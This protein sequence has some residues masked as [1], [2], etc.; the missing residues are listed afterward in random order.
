MPKRYVKGR[1]N[2]AKL[3]DLSLV[4][5]GNVLGVNGSCKSTICI[6]F[7]RES[8]YVWRM[9]FSS[10][11]S[12]LPPP[13]PFPFILFEQIV[14]RSRFFSIL[15]QLREFIYIL[16]REKKKGEEEKKYIR[17]N[18]FFSY[19]FN[20]RVRCILDPIRSV[21]N[22]DFREQSGQVWL[23]KRCARPIVSEVFQPA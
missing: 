23:L 11:T 16:R 12:S 7:A 21:L 10:H 1:V 20:T 18:K 13:S 14:N 5:E 19:L 4:K 6:F 17:D 2:I 8:G 15:A 9:H 3:V 22:K